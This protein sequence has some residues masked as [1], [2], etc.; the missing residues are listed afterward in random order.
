MRPYSVLILCPLAGNDLPRHLVGTSIFFPAEALCNSSQ[1]R[2]AVFWLH[3]RQEI[4]NAYLH[5]RSVTTD[6]SNCKFESEHEPGDDDVWFHQTLYI[7]ANVSKW[8]FGEERSHA[9]WYELCT[10]VDLWASRRPS[11]FDPIHF[12]TQAPQNGKYFPEVCYVTGTL[13]SCPI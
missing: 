7:T 9:R 8:A 3:L 2:R 12:C 6:L 5:Q 11:S 10:M 1:L 4:Y 13:W